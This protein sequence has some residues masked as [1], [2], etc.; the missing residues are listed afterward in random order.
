MNK[1]A[2]GFNAAIGW[3]RDDFKMIDERLRK[4][5]P[6]RRLP[7]LACWPVICGLALSGCAGNAPRTAN[8]PSSYPP[9]V[10][11]LSHNKDRWQ[12]QREGN[13]PAPA[14]A[15]SAQARQPAPAKAPAPDPTSAEETAGTP[16]EPA[17]DEGGGTPAAVAEELGQ[18]AS[19]TVGPSAQT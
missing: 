1:A 2:A 13:D 11:G 15:P 12:C 10:C 14:A 5:N 8:E 7:W 17:P 6:A 18:A 16:L 19:Q 9:W 3:I 4:A